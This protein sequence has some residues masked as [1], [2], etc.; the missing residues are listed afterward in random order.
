MSQLFLTL[1]PHLT[2]PQNNRTKTLRPEIG[3]EEHLGLVAIFIQTK[4][5]EPYKIDP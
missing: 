2:K 1:Y 5:L 4:P 3:R